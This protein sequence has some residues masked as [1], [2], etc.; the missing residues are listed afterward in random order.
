EPI[1]TRSRR[2]LEEAGASCVLVGVHPEYAALGLPALADDVAAEGPLAGILAL[3][4]HANTRPAI[5]IAC[6]MPLIAPDILRRLIEAAAGGVG[7]PPRHDA[8]P[9]K[10]G[11]DPLT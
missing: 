10:G 2:I 11:R 9:G 4:A 5:A 1:V 3:L 8:V 7:A 6:D